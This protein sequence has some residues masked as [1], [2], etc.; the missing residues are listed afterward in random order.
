MFFR[1]SYLIGVI[2]VKEC[3]PRAGRGGNPRF[4]LAAAG[5]AAFRAFRE[6]LPLCLKRK[7]D[8]IL[9]KQRELLVQAETVYSLQHGQ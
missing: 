7:R 5:T 3:H 9:V 4:S 6:F 2:P 8:R 1:F